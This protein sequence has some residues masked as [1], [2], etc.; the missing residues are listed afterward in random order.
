MLQIIIAGSILFV[1][2]Q[3]Q[4]NQLVGHPPP[5]RSLSLGNK[6]NQA[7]TRNITPQ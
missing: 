6:Q 5:L 3:G 4:L 2:K 7:H 1:Q